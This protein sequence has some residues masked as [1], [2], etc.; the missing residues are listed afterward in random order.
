VIQIELIV[1]GRNKA[2]LVRQLERAAHRKVLLVLPADASW[3]RPYWCDTNFNLGDYVQS[4]FVF[5]ASV[6]L[7]LSDALLNDVQTWLSQFPGFRPPVAI[8]TVCLALKKPVISRGSWW[9]PRQFRE[10][11]SFIWPEIRS[12]FFHTT[13]EDSPNADMLLTTSPN[14]RHY[15]MPRPTS[16]VDMFHQVLKSLRTRHTK[17]KQL[18]PS[19]LISV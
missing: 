18:F 15:W 10:S 1:G 5:F 7:T 16:L 13:T 12:R 17:A 9:W 14:S 3:R 19:I 4:N 11:P 6:P 2:A 8:P